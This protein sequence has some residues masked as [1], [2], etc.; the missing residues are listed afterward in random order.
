[1]RS[2]RCRVLQYSKPQ[3]NG[4]SS[5]LDVGLEATKAAQ[6]DA[7]VCVIDFERAEEL[8]DQGRQLDVADM[9]RL[10]TQVSK[11]EKLMA[12][13]LCLMPNHFRTTGS[14]L[15]LTSLWNDTLRNHTT[16]L[17]TLL[18]PL[19]SASFTSSSST[20]PDRTDIQRA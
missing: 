15:A 17:S 2:M 11:A 20:D 7:R 16:H 19:W 6:G 10:L 1:M 4:T 8:S 5:H 9:E 14:E 13:A 3:T 18:S 12:L